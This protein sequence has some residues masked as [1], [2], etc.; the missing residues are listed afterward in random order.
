MHDM[1]YSKNMSVY[2]QYYNDL[3]CISTDVLV[4]V[5]HD[6]NI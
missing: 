6:R 3:I 4:L 1:Y 2:E 5:L